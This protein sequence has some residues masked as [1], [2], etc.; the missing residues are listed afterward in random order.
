LCLL[1]IGNYNSWGEPP[2]GPGKDDAGAGVLLGSD[3]LEITPSNGAYRPGFKANEF[4]AYTAPVPLWAFD[5]LR[6]CPSLTWQ[7]SGPKISAQ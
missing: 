4:A 7:I 1:I 6:T 5:S 2:V 3:Q